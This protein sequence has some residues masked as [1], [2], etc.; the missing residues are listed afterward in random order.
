MNKIEILDGIYRV[1][2]HYPGIRSL[3]LYT[4]EQEF[5]D[6]IKYDVL[7]FINQ[8]SKSDISNSDH[9]TNWTGP[10]GKAG[11]YSLYNSTGRSSDFSTDHNLSTENKKFWYTDEFPSLSKFISGI[12]GLINFR[13]NVM[14]NSSG[15]SL[16]EEHIVHPIPS[17]NSKEHFLRVRFHLPIQTS[18][19]AKM[20][21]D[22]ED[23]NY[24]AGNIYYFNNGGV[25]SALNHSQEHDRI[26]LLWDCILNEEVFNYFFER[27]S[28]LPAV[29]IG[30]PTKPV[31]LSE[32][33]DYRLSGRSAGI[34]KRLQ[35]NRIGLKQKTFGRIFNLIDYS[36]PRKIVLAPNS[37]KAGR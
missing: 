3:D 31:S 17:A 2:Y 37:M 36:R 27:N 7:N 30:K 28:E 34:Y 22:G 16:H 20:S 33:P 13:C 26:H 29:F 14:G 35:L 1:N 21:I 25:H 11:Q 6:A 4:L 15:L 12:P 24:F 10:I 5:F 9:I 23:F 8:E 19:D 32:I 18:L